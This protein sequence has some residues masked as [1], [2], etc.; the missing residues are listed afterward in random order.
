[1]AGRDYVTPEDVGN[2]LPDV[3]A[4]RLVLFAKAKLHE[5]TAGQILQEILESVTKPDVKEIDL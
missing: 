3:C 2:V 1:M 4:H 5:Y